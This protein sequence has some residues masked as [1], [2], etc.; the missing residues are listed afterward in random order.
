MV[1]H[2]SSASPAID[3][4]VS[5]TKRRPGA[6]GPA[7]TC[8]EEAPPFQGG[9]THTQTLGPKVAEVIALLQKIEREFQPA[10]F[11]T[12]LG[13]EDMV[14]LDLI[15][16]HAPGIDVFTLDTGRLHPETYEL[17]AKIGDRYRPKVKVFFPEGGAVER[18]V[19]ING[20]NGFYDSIAQRKACCEVRKIEPLRRALAG[21]RAWLTG[22]RRE[23]SPTRTEVEVEEHDAVFGLTKFNPLLEWSHFE[24]WSYLRRHEVP[25]N[26]LHDRGFP[27]IGCAPCTR[28]IA[29]G[30]HARSG[31]WW[32]EAAESKECG[33]HVKPAF[34]ATLSN[35]DKALTSVSNITRAPTHQTQTQA[36]RS[37]ALR[38]TRPSHIEVKV[39]SAD[40][41]TPEE[42][43]TIRRESVA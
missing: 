39:A 10:A 35:E 24:I 22:L 12:S 30:E 3:G 32:W 17:L 33:L 9:V 15:A 6:A 31:R 1:D 14:L 16:K 38:A 37:R 43:E 42:I 28:A 36:P 8:G 11:A 40:S 7:Q 19:K 26:A 34:A 20:I 18:L 41:L 5:E 4:G 29:P 2:G 27:S 25:Y 21:Q 13:A 23:Q